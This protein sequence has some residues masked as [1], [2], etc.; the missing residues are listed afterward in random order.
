MSE[1]LLIQI[2]KEELKSLINDSLNESIARITS[3]QLS[4]VNDLVKIEDVCQALKLSKVTIHKWKKQ[5]LIPFHRI[6]N[7]I[8][9]KMTEVI[10]S[11]RMIQ[12]T[13]LK[14]LRK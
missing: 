9:F 1:I 5:G 14:G 7:R 10:D 8:F 4:P 6:S 2:S 3:T 11:L 12:S 13:K